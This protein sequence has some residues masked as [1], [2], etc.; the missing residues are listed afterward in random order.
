MSE[1]VGFLYVQSGPGLAGEIIKL[2]SGRNTLGTSDECRIIL[3]DPGVSAKH[4]SLRFEDD[5]YWLHDLDSQSG[6]YVNGE[7]V[8]KHQLQENDVIVLGDTK[9]KFKAL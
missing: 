8:V 6:T 2:A 5:H 3:Q 1:I 4:A 7:E 9:M